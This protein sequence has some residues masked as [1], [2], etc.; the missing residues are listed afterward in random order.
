MCDGGVAGVRLV[1]AGGFV[2]CRAA[3]QCGAE[4]QDAAAAVMEEAACV[5]LRAPLG[6]AES[7]RGLGASASLPSYSFPFFFF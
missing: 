3:A 1:I 6:S 4:L 2:A 5:V 7:T